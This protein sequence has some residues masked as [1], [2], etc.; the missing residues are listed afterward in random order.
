[1]SEPQWLEGDDH[2]LGKDPVC[3]ECDERHEDDNCG[4]YSND[5]DILYDEMHESW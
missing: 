4:V 3:N 1:M 5:P 2:A